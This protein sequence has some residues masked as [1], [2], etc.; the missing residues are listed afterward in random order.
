VLGGVVAALALLAL[1]LTSEG[2]RS[3]VARIAPRIR[4]TPTFVNAQLLFEE[5]NTGT[6]G[7]LRVHTACVVRNAEDDPWP[8]VVLHQPARGSSLRGEDLA[9]GGRLR[10]ALEACINAASVATHP[11]S[12]YFYVRYFTAPNHEHIEETLLHL[13]AR[14]PKS[15]RFDS[16]DPAVPSGIYRNLFSTHLRRYAPPPE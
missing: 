12:A 2:T 13:D 5:S 16:V 7:A 15:A 14:D 1:L 4:I 11:S 6:T 9:P 3:P 8:T 10:I